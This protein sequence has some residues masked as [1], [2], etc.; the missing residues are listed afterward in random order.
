[1]GK[2]ITVI[3]NSGVG[4][5]TLTQRLCQAVPLMH[6]L[7]QHDERPFQ[8]LFAADLRAYALANQIDY[9]L[10]RAEQE[11]AIRRSDCPGIQDGGLDQDFYVFTRFFFKR[12]YLTEDEYLLC[13]R[14]HGLLR[15]TLPPPDLIIHLTAP[16]DMLAKRYRQRSRTLEI[17]TVDDLVALEDL[18]DG[19]MRQST[20]STIVRVDASADDPTCSS[21]LPQLVSAIHT[22]LDR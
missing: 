21:C 11:L 2:L 4:K 9:L 16:L 22:L 15:Q 1:M 6:G 8:A 12:G 5:T 20:G 19:W 14:M 7:E 18:I 3:G 17:A 10:L 13:Q